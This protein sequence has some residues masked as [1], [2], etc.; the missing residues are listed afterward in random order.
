MFG[1]NVI[2]DLDEGKRKK[3][4]ERNEEWSLEYIHFPPAFCEIE[5]KVGNGNQKILGKIDRHAVAKILAG[6]VLKQEPDQ[7]Q[8]NAAAPIIEDMNDER[9][10][11]Q[12]QPEHDQILVR[13][14]DNPGCQFPDDGQDDQA[15]DRGLDLP[16]AAK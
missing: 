13:A 11:H 6:E 4:P 16:I 7:E 15:H 8:K 12:A 5:R 10:H 1:E 3:N 14:G 2:E 9:N